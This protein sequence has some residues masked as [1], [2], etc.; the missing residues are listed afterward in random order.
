M[1]LYESPRALYWPRCD[2]C[3]GSFQRIVQ[4]R[5][6]GRLHERCGHCIE[7]IVRARRRRR[8]RLTKSLLRS[9]AP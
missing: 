9:S 7:A 4:W 5:K 1:R 6:G 3:K 2:W 8:R